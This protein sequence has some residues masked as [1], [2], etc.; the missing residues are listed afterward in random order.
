M[1]S[2]ATSLSLVSGRF[3][4]SA[5]RLLLAGNGPTSSLQVHYSLHVNGQD[6]ASRFVKVADC[7]AAAGHAVAMEICGMPRLMKTFAAV[8][9]VDGGGAGQVDF[10]GVETTL[11][12]AGL[13]PADPAAPSQIR[14]KYNITALAFN[15]DTDVLAMGTEAGELLVWDLY[16]HK[17]LLLVE[18]DAVCVNKIR[19]TA[20]GQVAIAGSTNA[21]PAKIF[22]LRAGKVAKSLDPAVCTQQVTA[23]P[24]LPGFCSLAAHPSDNLLYCGDSA[25]AVVAWD[26]RSEHSA[27][28]FQPHASTVTDLLVAPGRPDWLLSTSLDGALR[29]W[30]P[31]LRSSSE[32]SPSRRPHQQS[33]GAD[34]ETLLLQPHGLHAMDADADGERLLVTNRVG[35][36]IRMDI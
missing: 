35:Q 18:V 10:V 15:A 20:S 33:T 6:G 3:L 11:R 17:Q 34:Y 22:D 4:G 12:S 2:F 13:H 27:M 28:H 24:K 8:S 30:C 9:T 7:K 1:E 31:K 19:F 23:L 14:H 21:S 5:D 29:R 26:L 25:G 32:L 36:V 16:A